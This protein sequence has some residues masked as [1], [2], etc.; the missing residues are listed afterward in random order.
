MAEVRWVIW[1]N[2]TICRWYKA[3]QTDS[4]IYVYGF[5]FLDIIS[6]EENN[7]W[8]VFDD[9]NNDVSILRT[10]VNNSV[11]RSQGKQQLDSDFWYKNYIQSFQF[12]I[13]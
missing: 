8:T 1:Q 5:F 10:Y 6:K 12:V 4:R 2:V 7:V 11:L 13:F 3:M 9:Q